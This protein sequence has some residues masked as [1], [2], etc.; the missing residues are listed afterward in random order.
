M[1]DDPDIIRARLSRRA[2]LGR[3]ALITP[4]EDRA[5]MD[6]MIQ[7]ICHA[8]QLVAWVRQRTVKAKHQRKAAEV[9]ALY[10]RIVEQ[11]R[12][13][14]LHISDND[15]WKKRPLHNVSSRLGSGEIDQ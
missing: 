10:R 15:N 3:R 7:F 9:A 4:P 5:R 13:A 8:L 6:R 2:Y 12:V 11:A 14:G 1:A